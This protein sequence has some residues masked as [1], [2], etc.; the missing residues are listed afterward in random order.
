VDN[1]YFQ[2]LPEVREETARVVFTGAMDHPPNTD[3]AWFFACHVFPL[4]Q[5]TLPEA[6]FWIV[7]RNPPAHVQALARV[8]GVIVT[9]FVPDIRPYMAQA[10]V[11]VVPLRF[12]SGM[13][14]KILEAWAMQKCVVSTRIG[15]EGLDYKEDVNI[16]IADDIQAMAESHPGD[17]RRQPA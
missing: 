8:P 2:P 3:A 15:A 4:V 9:G 10:T 5:Q 12:G 7:G 1:A 17:H 11:V 16:L 6:E 13:R 14:N